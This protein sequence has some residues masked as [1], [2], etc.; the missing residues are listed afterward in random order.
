MLLGPKVHIPF[1]KPD[2]I[3]LVQS[4]DVEGAGLSRVGCSA[5]MRCSGIVQT[6]GNRGKVLP[7]PY[8]SMPEWKTPIPRL[9]VYS[10]IQYCREGK[11]KRR[12]LSSGLTSRVICVVSGYKQHSSSTQKCCL[13]HQNN[14]YFSL[15]KSKV[16]T[17]CIFKKIFN[18]FFPFISLFFRMTTTAVAS[19]R[20][21][22]RKQGKH[23]ELSHHE[24]NLTITQ[25][26]SDLFNPLQRPRHHWPPTLTDTRR[27]WGITL[28]AVHAAPAV[29]Y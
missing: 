2:F 4:A 9:E 7:L 27:P 15:N 18:I 5:L 22:G 13:F 6:S 28:R 11:E 19:Q 3:S 17:I 24:G 1:L 29:P 21:P 12:G 26:R 8:I 16:L 23:P 10:F 20:A 14:Q 25:W